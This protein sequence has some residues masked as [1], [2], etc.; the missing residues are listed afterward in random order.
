MKRAFETPILRKGEDTMKKISLLAFVLVALPAAAAFAGSATNNLT[1]QAT[2]VANCTVS[3][4]TLNLGNYDPL[5]A[6]AAADLD[7]SQALSI[8]CTKGTA[9]TS[10]DLNNGSNF[11]GG[12]RMQLGA[13]GNF[14]NYEL[15]KDSGRT[16]V[17][18]TGAVKGIVPDASTSK[19]SDLKVGGA[20]LTVFGRVPQNQDVTIGSYADT[21]T[22]TI[23]F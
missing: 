20:A 13:T 11:S 3:A 17:W 6:N 8:K 19:N 2:V 7:A 4:A 15:Y 14:L 22:V 9:A 5:V 12:R 23:N 16:S 10:I 21:V 18:G 1:V